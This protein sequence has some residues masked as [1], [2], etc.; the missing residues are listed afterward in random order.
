[1]PGSIWR[2]WLLAVSQCEQVASW[3]A[4]REPRYSISTATLLASL[5]RTNKP[6]D[7]ASVGKQPEIPRDSIEG[8]PYEQVEEAASKGDLD[9]M[10]LL[11]K[12]H[13]AKSDDN[14]TDDDSHGKKA[15]QWLA[16]AAEAGDVS[17]QHSLAIGYMKGSKE[18]G[19]V[20]KKDPEKALK[21]F[22]K[23]AGQ[24]HTPS[25]FEIGKAHKTGALGLEKSLEKTLG[26][27]KKAAALGDGKAAY[28]VADMYI[29]GNE[30]VE[31]SAKDAISW[32]MKASESGFP[33]ALHNVGLMY[34]NGDG[35]QKDEE[36]ALNY[37]EEAAT[38]GN[39]PSMM[40]TGQIY[41]DREQYKTAMKWYKKAALLKHKA[42]ERGVNWPAQGEAQ[43]WM[44]N[45]YINGRGVE[46]DYVLAYSWLRKSVEHDLDE[47]MFWIAIFLIEGREGVDENIKEGM[48]WLRK[49]AKRNHIN[50]LVKLAD[51][52]S[53]GRLLDKDKE[54]ALE[55][56]QQA[57]R[58][59]EAAARKA[60]KGSVDPVL[61]KL[62]KS[63]DPQELTIDDFGEDEMDLPTAEGLPGGG[64]D[65]EMVQIDPN[66]LLNQDVLGLPS[67]LPPKDRERLRTLIAKDDMKRRKAERKDE[68]SEKRREEEEAKLRKQGIIKGAVKGGKGKKKIKK[69][70]KKEEL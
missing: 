46:V 11:T 8:Q 36:E 21:Y 4:S 2:L 30:I 28:H 65:A 59:D 43:L 29:A 47:A 38:K 66:D 14:S 69:K 64:A 9:S 52:Y 51:A 57:L 63:E 62:L 19:I 10:L 24:E 50:A 6:N 5:A 54:K 49:A 27:Y 39:L 40:S 3:A 7:K 37:F 70:V 45:A 58:H 15:V 31:Q 44:A 26:W 53:R 55:L 56:Y 60:M 41:N 34:M 68:K 22:I 67:D 1:M 12:Y 32:Y 33:N 20:I 23:A 25:M 42:G 35:V 18:G 13:G 61:K 16:K 17:S 48:K